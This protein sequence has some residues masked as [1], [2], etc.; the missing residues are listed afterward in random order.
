MVCFLTVTGLVLRMGLWSLWELG[1]SEGS[2]H[3]FRE[4]GDFFRFSAGT[5]AVLV[6][7]GQ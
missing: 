7:V 4:G 2:V 1:D 5:M 6:M 3:G